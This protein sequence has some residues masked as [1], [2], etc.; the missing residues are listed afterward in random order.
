MMAG[1]RYFLFGQASKFFYKPCYFSWYFQWLNGNQQNVGSL[2]MARSR[3]V[4]HSLYFFLN[5]LGYC[6]AGD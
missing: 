3:Q 5:H 6:L 4:L 2:K 1:L